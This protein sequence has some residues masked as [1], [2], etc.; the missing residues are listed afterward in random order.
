MKI[1]SGKKNVKTHDTKQVNLTNVQSETAQGV[2]LS[3]TMNL[4]TEYP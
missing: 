3:F 1:D 4:S 2:L